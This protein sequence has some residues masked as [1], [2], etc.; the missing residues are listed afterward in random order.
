MN[1]LTTGIASLSEF[2]READVR[3]QP[4]IRL[5]FD[6]KN[7]MERF[8]LFLISS[9]KPT[10]LVTPEARLSIQNNRF[11]I[12][13]LMVVLVHN[14]VLANGVSNYSEIVTYARATM[15][16]VDSVR[17]LRPE[18]ISKMRTSLR[19]LLQLLRA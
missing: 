14:E 7:D 3:K 19:S 5:T 11:E 17:V 6:T 12:E 15:N 2:I 13:G 9:I 4:E 1:R 16:E 8:R 10:D 18:T